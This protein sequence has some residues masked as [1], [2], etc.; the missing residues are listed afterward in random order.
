MEEQPEATVAAI[1]AFLGAADPIV[2]KPTRLKAD[3]VAALSH[4]QGGAGTS[5]QQGVKM[6]VLS[7]DPTKPGPYAI[8]L[9]VAAHTRIAA[10]SHRDDRQALVVSGEWHFG[11]GQKA[12]DADTSALGPG[13]FYT[14]PANTAHF[15]FTRDQAAT[16]FITGVGPTD[17][18]YVDAADAP[19]AK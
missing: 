8:E 3:D 1:R 10:H 16:V 2:L 6:V 15:A 5:G 13:G 18:Q 7:G 4:G 12:Y 9:Q 17:T 19:T 14:E 11:Y